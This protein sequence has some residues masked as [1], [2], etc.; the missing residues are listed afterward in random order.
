MCIPYDPQA[1]ALWEK[2]IMISPLLPSLL[3]FF[4]FS[5]LEASQHEEHKS[6]AAKVSFAYLAA[7]KI[8]KEVFFFPFR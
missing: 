2:E 5:S 4:Y 6:L 8:G 3:S 1:E 7:E